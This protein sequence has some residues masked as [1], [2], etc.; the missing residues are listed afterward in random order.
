MVNTNPYYNVTGAPV[1]ASRG[2]SAVIDNEFALIQ[3]GFD[4]IAAAQGIVNNGGTT[5]DATAIVLTSTSSRYQRVNAAGAGGY[6][7]LPDATTLTTGAD[8]FTLE[9]TGASTGALSDMAIKNSAGVVLG[10]LT[11]GQTTQVNLV[12]NTSA[13]GVWSLPTCSPVGML[14]RNVQTFSSI[15]GGSGGTFMKVVAI[16]ATRSLLLIWG[17]SLHAVVYNSATNLYS[18]PSLIRASIST[19]GVADLVV[20]VLVASDSI[21]VVSCPDGGTNMQA[22]IIT[23]SGTSIAA[24]GTALP[25]TTGAA[26]T[27]IQDITTV[28]SAY[29]VSYLNSTTTIRTI[30]FT[31][32]GTT[33]ANGAEQSNTTTG[34]AY[35]AAATATTF[36]VITS[37]AALLSAKGYSI[38]GNTQTAGTTTTLTLTALDSLAIR[39]TS[40]GRWLVIHKNSG[41][42]AA[43][44]TMTT[45]VPAFSATISLNSVVST[46]NT[47]GITTSDVMPLATPC[48]VV[49]VTGT[50]ASS[51]FVTEFIHVK[52]ALSGAPV[53]GNSFAKSSPLAQTISYVGTPS[54]FS[55]LQFF[56]SITASGIVAYSFLAFQ[57]ITMA[58]R[59]EFHTGLMNTIQAPIQDAVNIANSR[60][61]NM[62]VGVSGLN[63]YAIPIGDGSKR[64]LW[65]PFEAYINETPKPIPVYT[66][67]A[68][69]GAKGEDSSVVWVP[70][71][72]GPE[73]IVTL[74]KFKLA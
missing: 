23:T 67:S 48:V 29:I 58:L 68:I 32:S 72:Q 39:L 62:L 51:R 71:S 26:L 22:V 35:V 28:G 11:P 25:V 42:K 19:T 74:Q 56:Q 4:G 16:D 61:N 7:Q 52:D 21:L 47:P 5:A 66:D 73:Q 63:N 1:A 12:D 60:R 57:G 49:A 41:A 69:Y 30:A 38:S 55:G 17:I 3:K 45:T 54:G 50:D 8:V 36:I 10:F 2:S 64:S 65:F 14:S 31:V 43:Y 13:A 15:V 44:M 6:W 37:T 27:R 9:C 46:I 20:G 33:P 34:P 40:A 18:A 53:L 70:Y 24:I 59:G